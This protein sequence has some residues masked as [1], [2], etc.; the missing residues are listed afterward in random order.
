MDLATKLDKSLI[1]KRQ[2]QAIGV[3]HLKDARFHILRGVIGPAISDGRAAVDVLHQHQ[4]GFQV[5]HRQEFKGYVH[6]LGRHSPVKDQAG[7]DHVKV[8]FRI[9]E[10]GAAVSGVKELHVDVQ[11]ASHMDE[12]G[13]PH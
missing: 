4:R 3:T 13:E 2:R 8:T 7:A 1:R 10:D 5:H 11:L 12:L 6:F 9:P